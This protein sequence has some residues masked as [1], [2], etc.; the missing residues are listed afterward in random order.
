MSSWRDTIWDNDK[1]KVYVIHQIEI[2]LHQNLMQNTSFYK[3]CM[4]IKYTTYGRNKCDDKAYNYVEQLLSS[5]S[6][7]VAFQTS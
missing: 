5:F 3:H 7:K 1:Q 4:S 2:L 6:M